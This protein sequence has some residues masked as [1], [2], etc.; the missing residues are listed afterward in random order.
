MTPANTLKGRLWVLPG[1]GSYEFQPD[2]GG[3]IQGKVKLR[4]LS[5]GAQTIA[6]E[7][8]VPGA[9]YTVEFDKD[10]HTTFRPTLIQVQP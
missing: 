4:K 2:V 9:N 10:P 7:L 3:I 6:L 8:L 5:S 1:S